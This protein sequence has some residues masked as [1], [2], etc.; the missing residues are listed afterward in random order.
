MQQ[1]ISQPANV[2]PERRIDLDWVRIGAFG[3]LILYHVG[4]FYVPWSWHIKSAHPITALEPLMLALNP[5]R[6]ALLFLISGVAT[7][8]MLRKSAVGG[9]L[10]ARSLR[11]L[12]PLIFGM[13]V[14]VPPQSY[15]QIVEAL[16]HEDGFVDFYLKR[17]FAFGKD[18][19]PSPCIMLPT[20]NHLW[21]VAYLW[22]YSMAL[23]FAWMVLPR[24]GGWIER[25]LAPLL[26][27]ILL[28]VVPSLLF[29]VF[30]VALLPNFPP[31]HAL[32]GDWYNHA[33][34]ASVFL[35]G[36]LL[37]HAASFW[38]AIQRQRWIALILAAAL[39]ALWISLPP[40]RGGGMPLRL[41]AGFAYGS[42]QWLCVAAVL[43]FA[44]GWLNRDS[45]TRRYLTEAIFPFYIVHQTAIIVIA[46]ALR[47]RGLSVG[48]EAAVI[49]GGTTVT[50]I[51]TY[52]IVRRVR[53]LRALFGLKPE[54]A[55]PALPMQ[56]SGQAVS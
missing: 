4:M 17:Y 34:F 28:L 25:Q 49:I 50:C 38:E 11:L 23:G 33:L 5:W 10:R 22:V 42:Y 39:Y 30:R 24:L 44:R 14:I 21:F 41:F 37:A 15:I 53:W 2:A 40:G 3:L 32:F 46:H 54:A 6:L 51:V 20:W 48:F 13:L 36:F 27:G 26:S 52:E 35:L 8:F 19:C 47:G 16:G 29:G 1:T 55:Q 31:T 18:F 12:I 9:L 43:G 7:R 45:A 56:L